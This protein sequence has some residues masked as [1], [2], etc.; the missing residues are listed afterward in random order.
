M[1]NK[2]EAAGFMKKLVARHSPLGTRLLLAMQFLTIVPVRIKGAI[3]E[4]ELSRSAV[5][6]PFIGGLQGLLCVLSAALLLRFFPADITGLLVLMLLIITNGGFH[7]DGLADTFDAMA[8]KSGGDEKTDRDKRLSVMKD[9]A[10]GAIGVIA[11]V[12]T[13]LLKYLLI[14][15]LLLYSSS[16]TLYSLLFLMPV[17]SRWIMVPAMYLGASARDNGL[18]SIFVDSVTKKDVVFSSLITVLSCLMPAELL[19]H[20]SNAS[21]ASLFLSLFVVLFLFIF[22]SVKF[23][24]KR[25]GG[26]TGDTLGAI[27]EISEI[28]FLMAASL[29]LQHFI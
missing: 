17:F 12:V 27:S 22:I 15:N 20:T 3:S 18:G 10:T 11:V 29:W 28:L 14:K 19:R 23:C 1:N 6:F 25:F 4:N 5:F 21:A 24:K 7:L 26:L 13:I 9:S 8:V 16:T 2:T